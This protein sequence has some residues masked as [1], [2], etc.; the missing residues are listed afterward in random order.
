MNDSKTFVFG[1]IAII[2]IVAVAG[3]VVMNKGTSSGPVQP[4]SL[5]STE[6]RSNLV[7]F[8]GGTVEIISNCAEELEK[9]GDACSHNE[10]G[11]GYCDGEDYET[12]YHL[13]DNDECWVYVIYDDDDWL[14]GFE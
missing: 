13:L 6:S 11:V 1:L 14:R 2:A 5:E 3:M 4:V 10:A 7:G 8:A 12:F 9:E